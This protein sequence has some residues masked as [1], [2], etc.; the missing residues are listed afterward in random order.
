MKSEGGRLG[1]LDS[2]IVNLVIKVVDSDTVTAL[3]AGSGDRGDRRC[4]ADQAF[5]ESDTDGL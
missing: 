2:C 1:V 5:V 4:G 3:S